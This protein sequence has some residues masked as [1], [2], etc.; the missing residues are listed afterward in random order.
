MYDDDFSFYIVGLNFLFLQFLCLFLEQERR[1]QHQPLRD[2]IIY[3]GLSKSTYNTL[4][5]NL[6]MLKFSF[7]I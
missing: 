1:V 2:R 6:V 7:L 5:T 4:P 3:Q